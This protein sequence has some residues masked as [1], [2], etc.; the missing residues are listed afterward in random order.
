MCKENK[1]DIIEYF[2]FDIATNNLCEN[3]DIKILC[4]G[5]YNIEK[6][7]YKI[8]KLRVN[9]LVDTKFYFSLLVSGDFLESDFK[10]ID[11]KEFLENEIL[12]NK[13]M[14]KNYFFKG[15]CGDLESYIRKS[16]EK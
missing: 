15:N 8:Y 14:I 6:N 2:V 7:I 3:R 1:K 12:H 10:E 5:K 13:D 16:F 4:L 9:K 11:I